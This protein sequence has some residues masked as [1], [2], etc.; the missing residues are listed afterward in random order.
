MDPFTIN[1]SES[2]RRERPNVLFKGLMIDLLDLLKEKLGFNS[3]L[4]LVPDGKYGKY[5][6]E[7]GQWN[8]LVGEIYKGV[9][10]CQLSIT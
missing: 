8:G 9:R 10:L 7:T 4:Y 2:E 6:I 1:T 3:E 5:D